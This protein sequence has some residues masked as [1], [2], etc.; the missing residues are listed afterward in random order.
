MEKGTIVVHKNNS[1]GITENEPNTNY[2]DK[3][4]DKGHN[5]ESVKVK[6]LSGTFAN[7]P[8]SPVEIEVV[9]NDTSYYHSQL[10]LANKDE[11][12]SVKEFLPKQLLKINQQ[13]YK[14]EQ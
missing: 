9:C 7:R 10:R 6:W 5:I 8:I 11:K 12:E 14:K 13:F 1:I 4:Y 3:F 2:F